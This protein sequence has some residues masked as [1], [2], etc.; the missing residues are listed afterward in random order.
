MDETFHL[1]HDHARADTA[2]PRRFR[3]SYLPLLTGWVLDSSRREGA[4]RKI[5]VERRFGLFPT[6]HRATLLPF[7]SGAWSRTGPALVRLTNIV[8]FPTHRGI[9]CEFGDD[10][11]EARVPTDTIPIFNDLL[12]RHELKGEAECLAVGDNYPVTVSYL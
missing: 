7:A 5:W 9:A 12:R 6:F 3:A 2:G 8:S 10:I 4:I 11:L 1:S